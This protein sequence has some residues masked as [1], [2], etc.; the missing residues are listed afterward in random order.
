LKISES[1]VNSIREK[2]LSKEKLF[3]KEHSNIRRK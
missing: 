1:V 3:G 2:F